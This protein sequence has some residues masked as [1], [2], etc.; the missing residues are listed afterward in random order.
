MVNKK[1]L[2]DKVAIAKAS[3]TNH[4]AQLQGQIDAIVQ[5]LLEQKVP[6]K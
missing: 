1:D 4:F 3:S 6:K 2:E 5:Y